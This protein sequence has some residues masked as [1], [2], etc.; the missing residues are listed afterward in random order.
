[1]DDD[2]GDVDAAD[3]TDAAGLDDDNVAATDGDPPP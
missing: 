3:S 2:D 1:M